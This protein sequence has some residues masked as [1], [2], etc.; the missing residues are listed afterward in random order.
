MSGD[1]KVIKNLRFWKQEKK[2]KTEAP[3]EAAKIALKRAGYKRG[4]STS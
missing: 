3:N 1:K 4:S 2:E